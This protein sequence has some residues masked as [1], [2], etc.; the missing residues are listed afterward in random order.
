MNKFKPR[1]PLFLCGMMGSGKSTIGKQLA[2][3]LNIPFADLDS[4]IEKQENRTIPEIFA[5]E[6]EEAFR[7][8]E[9]KLLIKRAQETEGVLA[10]G[11]GS[12]QNQQI[13]DHIKLQGWLIF[14]NPPRAVL[15][16]RLKNSKKRPML[17]SPEDVNRQEIIDRL[18][19]ERLPFYSQAHITVNTGGLK[20]KEIVDLI[21][22]KLKMYE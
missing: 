3:E 7:T 17:N 5:G 14:I 10:L 20:K 4:L 21:I 8:I 1:Q 22:Q 18:I 9:Q 19:D 2:K 16:N 11:G 6:G 13:T 15:L 12:L